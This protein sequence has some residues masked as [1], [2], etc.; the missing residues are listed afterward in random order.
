MSTLMLGTVKAKGTK[1]LVL[2]MFDN[3]ED[4]YDKELIDEKGTDESYK[5][6]FEFS[7]RMSSFF[8]YE[9]FQNYSEEFDCEIIAT[10]ACEEDEEDEEP[11]ILHYK[12]GKIIKGLSD[13]G[14]NDDDV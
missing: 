2:E 10:M 4:Y 3:L 7:S 1:K 8:A 5:I 12:C 6:E 9:Y 14:I 13:Y 11:M